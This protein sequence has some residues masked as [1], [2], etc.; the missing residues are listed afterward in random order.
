MGRPSDRLCAKKEMLVLG[1]CRPMATEGVFQANRNHGSDSRF[2]GPERILKY[3]NARPTYLNS[4]RVIVPLFE[5]DTAFHVGQETII[6]KRDAKA[7]SDS[8]D[9]FSAGVEVFG[10]FFLS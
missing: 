5:R 8:S 3:S 10:L 6:H 7:T 2:I 9:P 1:L 4:A